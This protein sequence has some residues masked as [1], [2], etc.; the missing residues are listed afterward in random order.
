MITK[1]GIITETSAGR[2]WIRTT[3]SKSCD[4]C[5]SKDSCGEHSKAEEMTVQVENSLD[6]ATGD[7][8]VVGFRTAPLLKIAFTLYIFPI[9]LMIVGAGIGDSIAFGLGIDKSIMSMIVGVLFFTVAFFIIRFINNILAEKK[10]YQPFLMRLIQKSASCD[11]NN[12]P[13]LK[14]V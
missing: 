5:V 13:P 8:V 11:T 2:A 6:A 1:E 14:N 9:I 12:K 4:S 10:E 3:R 7:R